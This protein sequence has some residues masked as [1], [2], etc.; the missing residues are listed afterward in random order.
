MSTLERAIAIAAEA[1]TGQVD[2]AG[3]PYVLHPLRV[4]QAMGSYPGQIVGLLHDVVEDSPKGGEAAHQQ[5]VDEGFGA[6]VLNALGFLYRPKL[7]PKIKSGSR[8]D[9]Y[10]DRLAQLAPSL[11]VAAKIA[12]LEDNLRPDRLALLPLKTAE[13][14]FRRYSTA[15]TKLRVAREARDFES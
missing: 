9:A 13:S 14:L 1:H 15:L 3:Y 12:D 10:I 7:D 4:M 11:A 5:L 8:Y 2:K 6:D